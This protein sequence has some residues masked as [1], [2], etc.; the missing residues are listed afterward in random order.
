MDGGEARNDWAAV[1]V[2]KSIDKDAE[3]CRS[4]D[5]LRAT[6]SHY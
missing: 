3:A 6:L 2:D 4:A 1:V 5:S